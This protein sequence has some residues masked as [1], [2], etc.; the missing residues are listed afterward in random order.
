MSFQDIFV[1]IISYWIYGANNYHIMKKDD[2][3]ICTKKLYD[4]IILKTKDIKKKTI[5]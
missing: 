2:I 3:I 1:Q 5:T 4:E